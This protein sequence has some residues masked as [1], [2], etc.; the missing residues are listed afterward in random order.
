MNKDN[1]NLRTDEQNDSLRLA[2]QS[3]ER[4]KQENQKLRELVIEAMNLPD[5]VSGRSLKKWNEF[6]AKANQLLG[7]KGE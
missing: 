7:D 1:P 2:I 3:Y 6:L 4:L 5:R